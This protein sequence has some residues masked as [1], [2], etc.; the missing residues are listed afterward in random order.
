MRIKDKLRNAFI[1]TLYRDQL[2]LPTCLLLSRPTEGTRNTR[3]REDGLATFSYKHLIQ[4][5]SPFTPS[6]M[7]FPDRMTAA[8][9]HGTAN[10][11]SCGQCAIESC[12]SMCPETPLSFVLFLK[13]QS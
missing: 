6:L 10:P 9:S 3:H 11:M 7:L 13:R 12:Q 4:L 5:D 2:G 8:A 1:N